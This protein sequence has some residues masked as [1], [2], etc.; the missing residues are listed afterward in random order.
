MDNYLWPFTTHT[1]THTHTHTNTHTHTHTQSPLVSLNSDTQNTSQLLQQCVQSCLLYHSLTNATSQ[2]YAAKST[3][4]YK[5]MVYA[6][7]PDVL[8]SSFQFKRVTSK[9]EEQQKS[10]IGAENV[11][12]S[13]YLEV[14]AIFPKRPRTPPA[15]RCKWHLSPQGAL[16][17]LTPNCSTF[18]A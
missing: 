4:S 9:W 6:N 1:H 17:Q 10:P 15:K 13:F 12:G 14:A 18:R 2:R 5:V 3:D 8:G 7:N 16:T 11:R